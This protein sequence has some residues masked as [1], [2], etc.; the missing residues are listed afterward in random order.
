M[1]VA[2]GAGGGGGGGRSFATAARPGPARP[3]TAVC[4]H[5]RP[6]LCYQQPDLPPP[7]PP[8]TAAVLL[9]RPR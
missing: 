3:T 4:T 9:L 5:L 1:L 6:S 7:P 8:P 2:L